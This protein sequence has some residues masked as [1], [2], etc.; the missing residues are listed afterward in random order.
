MA[1]QPTMMDLQLLIQTLQGQVQALQVSQHAAPNIGA[2]PPVAP[3]VTFATTP[4]ALNA[5][6]LIDDSTKQGSAIFEQGCQA[7][8]DKALVDGFAMMPNQTIIFVEAFYHRAAAMGW[9]QGSK[10]ITNFTNCAGVIVN[11]IK[12]YGQIFEVTL[13]T[14]C[15]QFCKGGEVNAQSRATQNNAMM[16]TCLTK[17]LTANAQA[18]VLTYRSKFTLDSMEYT[19]LMYKIIMR[20]TTADVAEW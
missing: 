14:A 17:S 18:C 13:K 3:T 19:P 6:D 11:I 15:K 8:D 2:A 9:T 12:C 4:Q 5:K 20:L 1:Q 10:Q 7:L 16:A